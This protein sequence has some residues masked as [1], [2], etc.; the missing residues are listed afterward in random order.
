MRSGIEPGSGYRSDIKHSFREILLMDIH[1]FQ[2]PACGRGKILRYLGDIPIEDIGSR[3]RE[4]AFRLYRFFFQRQHPS[5]RI[6]LHHTEALRIRDLFR[7]DSPARPERPYRIGEVVLKDIVPEYECHRTAIKKILAKDEGFRQS[8]RTLLDDK[9]YP[10]TIFLK[11]RPEEIQIVSRIGRRNDQK[12]IPNTRTD[13]RIERIE[14]HRPIIDRQKLF[15]GDSRK[16]QETRPGS[17]RK[18]N[19]FHK[20]KSVI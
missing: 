9:G 3:N 11:H 8:G 18:N 1:N 12:N 15:R 13:K 16:R 2:F 10:H 17:A 14:H 4:T 20:K 5:F 7:E 6:E 19:T